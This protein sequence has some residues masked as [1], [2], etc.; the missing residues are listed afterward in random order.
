MNEKH[1]SQ[2]EEFATITQVALKIQEKTRG[3]ICKWPLEGERG[4][5]FPGSPEGLQP[6]PHDDVSVLRPLL[7]FWPSE[8][9]H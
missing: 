3:K 5:L 9:L 2:K 1:L 4:S 8:I 6:C 7:N